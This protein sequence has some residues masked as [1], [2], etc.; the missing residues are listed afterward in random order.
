QLREGP[1]VPVS[2]VVPSMAMENDVRLSIA[3]A[4]GIA[5][6]LDF[7]LLTDFASDI[8]AKAT[9]ERV[10]DASCLEAMALTQILDAQALA[11]PEL[12]PVRAYLQS[13]GDDTADAFDLR[14][15][16]LAA[17]I[18]RVFEEYT[19][20]RGGLLAAWRSGPAL[21][22]R[23]AEVESWQRQMYVA[24]FGAEGLAERRAAG[25]A[26]RV[27]PL[28]EAV[29]RLEIAST[30]LP[31][32]LH[33]FGFPH[34]ARSFHELLER[35]GRETEIIVYALSACEG[36]WE[37]VEASDPQLLLL[38]G[39]PGRDQ[40]RAL[41][42]ISS[43]DHDD[44]F[45]DPLVASPGGYSLLHR[46]QSDVLARRSPGGSVTTRERP[47]DDESITVLEHSSL[48]REVEVVASEIWRICR[49]DARARF[50]DFAL[51]VPEADAEAYAAIVPAVFREAHDIPHR[52][53]GVGASEDR[54]AGAIELLLSLPLGRF[55]RQELLRVA[56]HPLVVA[57]IEQVA[58]TGEIDPRQWI[59]WSDALGIVSGADRGDHG[60]TYV[61][62]DVL[63]WDQG[64]RRLALGS[65]MAGDATGERSA[66]QVGEHHY[67]P[68]EVSPGD[69]GTAAAFG[70]LSRSL[71]EDARFAR[72]SE[73]T[74]REWA[75]FFRLLVET[76]VAPTNRAEQDRLTA[77]L[78]RLS[79]LSEF[80]IGPR[81]LRYRAACEV[82]RARLAMMPGGRGTE[83][84]VVSTLS[85]AR[86]LSFR[87]AFA[88]GMG[89]G[90]FPSPEVHDSLDLRWTQRRD[91]DVTSRERDRYAFLELVLC[92]RERLA[93]SYVS[94]DPVT[95]DTLAPSSVVQELMHTLGRAYGVDPA[96]L[97]RRHPLHRWDP[98]YF[99]EV[100][101]AAGGPT[102]LG[103]MCMPE[104]LAEARTLALRRSAESARDPIS[105]EEVLARAR[106]EADWRSLAEHLRL[107]APPD[108]S[109]RT[110]QRLTIPL[111]AVVRFLEFPLQGWARFRL[112]LDEIEDDDVMDRE[113]EWFETPLRDATLLLRNVFLDAA[114]TKRPVELVYDEEVVHREL[115]GTGPSGVFARGERDDHVATLQAWQRGLDAC[116]VAPGSIE[117]CRF[118][119]AGESARADRIHDGIPIDVDV[120][121][122]AGVMRRTRVELGG[123][124][125]PL[126]NPAETSLLL[127]RRRRQ[128]TKADDWAQ[129]E[130][131]R[132]F[133]RAF[134]EHAAL[135]AS[136]QSADRPRES[137]VL[138]ATPDGETSTKRMTF[139]A[140]S[141]SDATV[142]LR[143][144]L[145]DLLQ[146]PH[147]YFFPC[148]AVFAHARCEADGA[149]GPWLEAARDKVGD[150]DDRSNLRSAYGPIPRPAQYGAPDEGAARA[151]ARRRFGL[152]LD[153]R[154]PSR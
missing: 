76:Y 99:P 102:G 150:G 143:D 111:Y 32:A 59:D 2:M 107:A 31:R 26:A 50:D 23:A 81:R 118:G 40:A 88:C 8:V 56:V 17:R 67:V 79:D 68:H 101:P 19:Y 124:I 100:F 130:T 12:A 87:F 15:V 21:G 46:V 108:A 61:T 112:G 113:D 105:P 25:G 128:A 16:Q 4:C 153:R 70:L 138:L 35:L 22:E 134:V 120:V 45:V 86:G 144:V 147:A 47:E 82:A 6:N 123:R 89:E 55:T 80:D 122:H 97:R 78:R 77:A 72:R 126:A 29:A 136:G 145:R 94:R 41:N 98:V 110:E 93:L 30:A 3:R 125:L 34:F 37:D 152:M 146:G 75:A 28:C 92:T 5:A 96:A 104:A 62:R 9:G 27:V 73:L 69:L 38:W 148:E 90:R 119:R 117:L 132:L 18:A 14:S 11:A 121:D 154:S 48:R 142:W 85:A 51:F 133:L 20:S 95:G 65:F 66:F 63:S 83:G 64:L 39:R 139:A 13:G 33:V 151:M 1:L 114:A 115:R 58:G 127:L 57:S 53:I 137:I 135:S 74:M 24:M 71:I 52:T 131:D 49:A 106:D 103:T 109:T 129:A 116:G 84:V 91:G 7:A 140:L 36:F 141:S 54:V 60:G 149:L 44:R 43:F 10:A 42:A